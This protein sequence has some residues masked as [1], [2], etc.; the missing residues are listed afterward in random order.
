MKRVKAACICQT[1]HFMLKEDMEH[2][3][4][5]AFARQEVEHY[6]A[7]LE[8]KHTPVSY[9]HLDVYKRQ[10]LVGTII[11]AFMIGV[12]ANGMNLLVIPTGPQRVVTG[13]IIVLAVILDVVRKG[14]SN[15][16]K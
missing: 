7:S 6:K 2:N 13:A 8:R 4:A 10:S 3:A 15:R 14:A 16:A 5:V 11:G 1:L 12:I 9:T